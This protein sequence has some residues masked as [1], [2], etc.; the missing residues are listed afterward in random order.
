MIRIKDIAEMCG[1]STA[2]VS[3]V[4]HGKQGKVSKEFRKMINTY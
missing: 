3:Y 2:T 1:V 4:I